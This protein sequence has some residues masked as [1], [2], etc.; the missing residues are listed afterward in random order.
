MN[1][2]AFLTV[3]ARVR[4]METT[5]MT[6]ARMER[7]LNA[8]SKEE[9]DRLLRESG[10]PPLDAAHP[11]ELDAALTAV[12]TETLEELGGSVPESGFLDIFRL[13]YDYHNVKT[14]LKAAAVG[15][16]PTRMLMESGRV[17]VQTLRRALESG[18][19]GALPEMLA[20]AAAEGREALDATHDPQRCDIV[21]DRWMYRD[22]LQT[23]ENTG[24]VFLHGYVMTQIDAANLRSLI[25]VLRMGKGT[26]FLETVLF[27][28][29]EIPR[30][31]VLE[32]AAPGSGLAELYAATRF[33]QAA[34]AGAAALSGGSLTE[35]ERLCDDAAADY[36]TGAQMIPFGEAPLLAYLAARETEAVDL[37]ILLL[38][39]AAGL[40]A[41]VLRARLRKSCV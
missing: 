13:K 1:D 33:A 32:T 2:T 10:Y 7:L 25:R 18:A 4:A 29:G 8:R 28:G 16:D 27:D 22:M 11:E 26:A 3:S 41:A 34:K 17:P 21:L 24:S 20:D 35:F 23:A 38:G 14:L 31:C 36:L 40:P 15:A 9:T 37:R 12:W 6:P 19:W 5:L 39:R 30:T